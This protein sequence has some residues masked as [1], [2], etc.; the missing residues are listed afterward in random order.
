MRV[1]GKDPQ[2]DTVEWLGFKGLS[3]FPDRLSRPFDTFQKLQNIDLFVPGALRKIVGPLKIG[4]PYVSKTPPPIPNPQI[5]DSAVYGYNSSGVDS[6]FGTP[7]VPLTVELLIP[8]DVQPGDILIAAVWMIGY[9]GGVGAHFDPI[10]PPAGWTIITNINVIDKICLMMR[11]IDGTEGPTVDFTYNG[12]VS[13]WS[14]ISEQ[15]L[16]VATRYADPAG[17]VTITQFSSGM[18]S[19][20]MNTATGLT[21]PLNNSIVFAMMV[22]VSDNLTVANIT[23]LTPQGNTN[24][25]SSGGLIA[26]TAVIGSESVAVA[27]PTGNFVSSTG[28]SSARNAP[29]NLVFAIQPPPAVAPLPPSPTVIV[30]MAAYKQTPTTPFVDIGVGLDG[31]L[32]DIIAGT[33]LASLGGSPGQPFVVTF[34]GTAFSGAAIQ[35]LISTLLN[36]PPVKYDGVNVTQI[37][38]SPAPNPVVVT[39]TFVAAAANAYLM[40]VGVQY[41]WTY[42]NSATLHESSPSPVTNTSIITQENNTPPPN[43][44]YTSQV[45]L[46]IATPNPPIGSGYNR[47]RVY[48]TR[49]GG[50]TFFLIPTLYSVSGMAI[51]DANNSVARSTPNTTVFDGFATNHIGPTDDALLVNPPGGAPAIGANNPPPVAV[52]GAVYQSRLWLVKADLKTIV[53]SNLGDFQSF[54]VN[55]FF[56]FAKDILDEITAVIA[57][58]DRLIIAGKNTARQITGVNFSTFTLVP[59]DMRRGILG[60]RAAVND[61][62]KIYALSSESL[63]RMGFAEGGPP[64]IGDHIKPLTDSIQKSSYQTIIDMDI[65]APRAILYFAVKI[66]GVNYNDQIILADLSREVPFTTVAGLPTE[67]ITLRSLEF[68]D[69]STDLVFSGADGFVYRLY[70]NQGGN[71]SLVAIAQTQELPL[72]DTDFWKV[73]QSL[74]TIIQDLSNWTIAYSVDQGQTFTAE[75]P[76]F[77]KRPIGLQGQTIIIRLTHAVN[78]GKA[79]LWSRAKLRYETKM[80]MVQ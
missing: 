13:N 11:V 24:E 67:L 6:I 18:R 29:R 31:S 5:V 80:G 8:V 57:L 32:Y 7:T 27:G 50:A 48:R 71:G 1:K 42:F 54:G 9:S 73:F 15:V 4:G 19:G 45:K 21:T 2:S 38:C 16:M 36:A 68:A 77:F 33:F 49:D 78:N 60:R 63:A 61:G 39:P 72:V 59:V 44:P 75:S 26:N 41:L 43:K 74:H 22:A 40:Q 66:N 65:D 3:L 47:I 56:N 10:V 25:S 64:F 12:T 30:E 69:G 62:D 17:P 58:S 37:G 20:N 35:Y 70:D 14:G 79:V 55:N 52:W 34:P 46:V 28:W 51:S 23:G 76:L 53:F